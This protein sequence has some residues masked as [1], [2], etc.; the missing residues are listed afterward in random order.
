MLSIF[1][2]AFG[3]P[4][5]LLWRNVYLDIPP[6]FVELFLYVQFYILISPVY[7]NIN[8]FLCYKLFAEFQMLCLAHHLN[9][10]SNTFILKPGALIILALQVR[11]LRHKKVKWPS[12]AVRTWLSGST[13]HIITWGCICIM[14]YSTF[15]RHLLFPPAQLSFFIAPIF[16][17]SWW[18]P[19]PTLN[20][21]GVAMGRR[22]VHVLGLT[23]QC[24][25]SPWLPC[26]AKEGARDAVWSTRGFPQRQ[27]VAWTCC[28]LSR[29]AS[30]ERGTEESRGKRG[31]ATSCRSFS[32]S[33]SKAPKVSSWVSIWNA[34][35]TW[36][37]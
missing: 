14:F 28:Q 33:R 31:Q 21:T 34:S 4:V 10:L 29:G 6:F 17:S 11:K 26:L 23:S 35:V 27:D 16:P 37:F 2:C 20:W 18:V 7:F 1:S 30:W 24:P 19:P 13:V 36:A 8:M 5:C 25:G 22:W 9:E 3:P 12:V 32:D 15:F